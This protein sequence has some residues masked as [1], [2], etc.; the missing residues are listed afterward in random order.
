MKI[1]FI[2]ENKQ[3]K[4]TT[5]EG[6]VGR[7]M[8]VVVRS[9]LLFT[10]CILFKFQSYGQ[11]SVSYVIDPQTVEINDI[12]TVDVKVDFGT[13]TL[14]IVETYL[15][16]NPLDL[17]VQSVP[18]VP[19]G[20]LTSLPSVSVPFTSVANMNATGQIDYGRFTT[21]PDFD[22]HPNADFVFFTVTFRVLRVPPGGTT[23]I[24]FN[25]SIPRVTAARETTTF[26]ALASANPG[27]ITVNSAGCTT[28]L[29]TI[30][31][32]GGTI[33]CNS[34]SFNLVLASASNGTGPFDLTIEGPDGTATYNDIA[35]GSPITTFTPPTHSIWGNPTPQTYDDAVY[36]LG[37][38][39]TSSVSGFVKGIRFFAA[40]E[41]SATPGNY[42]GQLWS[43]T[44]TLLASGSFT[45]VTAGAWN[46]LVFSSPILI[47]AGETYVASY[48]LG[49][50]T[51]Y[52]SSSNS[53]V[54]NFTN[55]PLTALGS[56]G[57]YF[58]AATPTFPQFSVQANY[59]VDILFSPNQYS[60]NLTGV[61]DAV[62]CNNTGT[63]QTLN[64]TSVD[65]EALPVSLLNLSATPKESSIILTWATAMEQDN[66]GFEVQ[67]R[68]DNGEWY[69]IGYVKGAGTSSSTRNYS[70]TDEKLASGRYYYRLRQIDMDGRFE[71][72]PVVSAVI[73]GAENFSLDQN[74]PNPFRGETII[75]YSL[76]QKASVKLTLYDMHGRL[77]RTL[78]NGSKEKGTHAVTINS[79]TLSS[80]LYYYKLESD[81]FT[82]VKKM[83]IQ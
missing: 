67:R 65:C 69:K 63:L 70:Y 26:D 46:E 20:V 30:S 2:K 75:R 3:M 54:S 68:T 76:P 17:E 38:R 25:S 41:V 55:G 4:K 60:F 21:D 52:A 37:L 24:S 61:S 73:G 81:K 51:Y 66:A 32:P 44:G 7:Y 78:V 80:G 11:S 36:T 5:T 83:T 22:N 10:V 19:A 47:T 40:D 74:Y 18:T 16:F 34:Q 56:G 49:S 29:A 39:F 33:T 12:I 71:F 72:S 15:N 42:S 45:T 57:V 53:L 35:V 59:W 13:G 50:S 27:V 9:V 58:P 14:S 79:S 8:T 1:L 82:A 28:P 23:S 62:G 64:V 77:V 6:K 31:A 43:G 48:H